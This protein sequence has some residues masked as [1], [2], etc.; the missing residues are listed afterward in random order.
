MTYYAQGFERLSGLYYWLGLFNVHRLRLSF[1]AGP[2][3]PE[4]SGN[5]ALKE[6]LLRRLEGVAR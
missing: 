6:A 5:L 4:Y 1:V 2:T 3:P